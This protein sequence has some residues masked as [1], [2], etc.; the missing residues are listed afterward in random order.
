MMSRLWPGQKVQILEP[1]WDEENDEYLLPDEWAPEMLD[2]V[3]SIVTI[4]EVTKHGEV[5]LED[6]EGK[7]VWFLDDF[8]PVDEVS[9]DNPNLRF[10]RNKEREKHEENLARFKAEATAVKA[11]PEV[12]IIRMGTKNPCGEVTFS[13]YAN[14]WHAISIP[15]QPEDAPDEPEEDVPF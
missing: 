14:E 1:D 7:W 4:A 10:R 11:A 2:W 15:E 13:E 12:E 3:G 5:Y 8:A 6:D 9:T